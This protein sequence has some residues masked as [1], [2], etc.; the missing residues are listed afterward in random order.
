[1]RC[2]APLSSHSRLQAQRQQECTIAVLRPHRQAMLQPLCAQVSPLPGLQRQ[3]HRQH[4]QQ[5][6]GRSRSCALGSSGVAGISSS[7]PPQQ[8]HARQRLQPA[9][10]S[11]QPDGGSSGPEQQ[12][13]FLS[14]LY[15]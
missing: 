13:G 12:Q 8:R 4:Y 3:Q 5:Q 2:Q 15:K 14:N 1:M 10:A 11:G 7:W 9:A 6:Q